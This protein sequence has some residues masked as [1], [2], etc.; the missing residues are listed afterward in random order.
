MA[1]A[2]ISSVHWSD[3]GALDMPRISAALKKQ[4]AALLVDATHDAG[5]R[6]ID[7]KTLDP[8]FLIFPTYKWVLGPYGRAF[9]YIAKRWQN[10]VPLEQTAAARKAVSAED[11]IYFRDTS[12]RDDARRYD[13]GERDH[14][15]SMEMAAIGMEMMARWGNEAVVER[16]AMLTGRLAD[17]LGNL[18][19]RLVDTKLR[20]PHI[21]CVSFPNGMAPDLP[22]RLA[23]ENV[24]AAPRL[25][26][27]RISPHVYNDEQDVERFVEVFRKAA[28]Q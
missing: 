10:G 22:K 24:H 1:L 9:M 25:G 5:V 8:D 6:K 17:G 23:A 27:L 7:V 12:Y 13:M 4:G 21:L 26:R 2:S 19:V 16:L 28:F 11:T 15:V 18:G 20:A 3:G 14:F